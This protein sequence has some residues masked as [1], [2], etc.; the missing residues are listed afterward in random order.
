MVF[1]WIVSIAAFLVLIVLTQYIMGAII[2]S[3]NACINRTALRALTKI[4]NGDIKL[5]N[6]KNIDC[7][8]N[9]LDEHEISQHNKDGFRIII[10]TI[11]LIENLMFMT[12]TVA[13][14][15]AKQPDLAE[16]LFKLG[17]AWIGIKTLGS[18][19]LWTNSHY[20]RANFYVFLIGSVINIVISIGLGIL[21]GLA[22]SGF[23]SL[24]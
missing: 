8:T 2:R 4:N 13:L 20:S 19:N 9:T 24:V 5:R 11:G 18:Y 23:V 14:F 6:K 1:F 16:K 10:T 15:I 3:L 22:Y 12:A 21:F 7:V 17:F